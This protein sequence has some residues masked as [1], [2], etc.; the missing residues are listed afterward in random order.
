MPGEASSSMPER[1]VRILNLKVDPL[2]LLQDENEDIE[3]QRSPNGRLQMR[4]LLWRGRLR[5]SGL[6]T[7]E[8]VEGGHFGGDV[9]H[10]GMDVGLGGGLFEVYEER[11][12]EG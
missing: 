11:E 7:G 8:G 2:Q 3:R 6:K 5:R 9:G 10:E 12:R 1:R 4:V